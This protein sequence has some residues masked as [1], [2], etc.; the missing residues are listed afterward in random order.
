MN[1]LTSFFDQIYIINLASRQDRRREMIEQLIKVGVDLRNERVRF[2]DAIS[3]DDRGEFPSVGAKGC[4]MSHSAVLSEAVRKRY[5]RI[6]IF[7]DDLN[8]EDNFGPRFQN[9]TARLAEQGWGMFYGGHHGLDVITNNADDVITVL[10]ASLPVQTAHFIALNST[11]IERAAEYL[12]RIAQ[13]S[14]GDSRG[15]PMHVDG[16]YSW[17][18][19]DNSDIEVYAAT[20]PIGYQRPSRS[21]IATRRW[22]D[23]WPLVKSVVS[24]LRK[25]KRCALLP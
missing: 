24:F 11:T 20:P 8:F 7:E 9:V 25:L 10:P 23:R 15:G 17:F 3:P 2:F 21:D 13:R 19:K 5:K 1:T 4:F 18:R 16:A 14:A 12:E 6:A 22:F